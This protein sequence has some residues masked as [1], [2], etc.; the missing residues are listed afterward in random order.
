MMNFSKTFLKI[1]GLIGLLATVGLAV[2][3]WVRIYGLIQAS[4]R[5]GVEQQNPNPMVLVGT[6]VALIAGLLLGIGLAMPSQTFKKRYERTRE[7]E[8]E[9]EAKEAGFNGAAPAP[10]PSLDNTEEA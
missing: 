6:V 7:A 4:Q 9:S 8:L 3:N 10:R 5:F 1:L 2:F